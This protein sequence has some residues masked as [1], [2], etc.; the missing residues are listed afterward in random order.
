MK[1][2]QFN[3]GALIL[4][5]VLL[6]G[7]STGKTESGFSSSDR[8]YQENITSQASSK[9]PVISMIGLDSIPGKLEGLFYADGT[10]ALV[11]AD[12]LYL[13]DLAQN[14]I[15]AFAKEEALRNSRCW[16]IANG[17]AVFGK[18]ESGKSG[19]DLGKGSDS[20]YC[21]FFYD[22]TLKK[23]SELNFS[24]LLN[25][26]E[27]IIS[28][29]AVSVSS[30]GNQIAYATN[31]GLYL[32]DLKQGKKRTVVDMTGQNAQK[33]FGLVTLE[34]I[35]FTNGDKSIA[36]KAQSFDV[37][38]V[39]DK[40]SFDTCGIVGVNGSG[41]FNRKI[42]GYSTKELTAYDKQLLFAEDIKTAA[43]KIMVMESPGGKTKLYNLTAKDEGGNISGSDTGRYFASAVYGKTGWT[44]RVYDTSAGVLKTEQPISNGGQQKYD[45]NVPSVRIFDDLKIC[46]VLSGTHQSTVKTK[47]TA[48][49]F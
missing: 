45:E 39:T 34:Q 32:Y 48:F 25:K 15:I 27:N 44:V 4:L 46:I 12:K 33:R 14:K 30:D 37:P 29:E 21:C 38:P 19:G 26:R 24:Q 8:T 47:I 13:Y 36:F 6:T 49:A 35:G 42:D 16:A 31:L 1:R 5:F 3:A 20:Q 22:R 10:N 18:P 43:G 23:I 17:Y 9:A 2:L 28:P 41:L 11:C 7:C 40:P